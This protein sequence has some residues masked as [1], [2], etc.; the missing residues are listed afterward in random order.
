M[1]QTAVVAPTFP[2]HGTIGDT[3]YNTGS[4][5]EAAGC[6]AGGAFSWSLAGGP[7]YLGQA[8]AGLQCDWRNTP[9]TGVLL[10]PQAGPCSVEFEATGQ[11]DAVLHVALYQG[12]VLLA[13]DQYSPSE[14]DWEA[15]SLAFDPDDVSDWDDL[16]LRMYTSATTA[17]ADIGEGG[18]SFTLAVRGI[19]IQI[20]DE[21]VLF[22]A[23]AVSVVG[24]PVLEATS[25]DVSWI[26]GVG[27]EALDHEGQYSL[28]NGATWLPLF[29]PQPGTTYAWDIEG[30][31]PQT[32]VRIRVRVNDG[33][34]GTW[35]EPTPFDILPRWEAVASPAGAWEPVAPPAGVW[36]QV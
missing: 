20:P 3:E 17:C 33:G 29:D 6:T 23:P 5:D 21:A 31:L 7:S 25:V 18:D 11:G 9:G 28:D 8:A 30:I 19:S 27:A 12:A 24:A 1:T 34:E 4:D 14:L 2:R 36:T 10:A 22:P 26:P 15:L 35:G 13:S 32:G 16:H